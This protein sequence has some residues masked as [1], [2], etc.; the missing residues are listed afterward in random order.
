MSLRRG[1]GQTHVLIDVTR[2][3]N[4]DRVRLDDSRLIHVVPMVTHNRAAASEILVEQGRI[5]RPAR[6]HI[7]GGLHGV[8]QHRA[9]A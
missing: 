9:S 3:G 5:P 4:L 1:V 2:I 8:H 6:E 7:I